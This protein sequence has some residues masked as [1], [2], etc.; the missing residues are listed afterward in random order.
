[1]NY[2]KLKNNYLPEFLALLSGRQKPSMVTVN[3]TGRCNQRCIYCEIGQGI[4]SEVTDILTSED[5]FWILDEMA[6]HGLHRISLCGGE[7]FLFE[8]L[9]DVIDY[10]SKKHIRCSIT[11]NGMTVFK[12]KDADFEILRRNNADI[13]LSI[14]SLNEE[15]QGLTRGV[16]T[17]L[18]NALLSFQKLKENSI[19]VTVLAAISKY[20]YR[21]L[22]D[23]ILN[24]HKIGIK[25]VLFQPVIHHSNYPDRQTLNDK[26]S[27]NIPTGQLEILMQ[28]L[29]QIRQFERKHDISTNVYR[30][31]P[32]IGAYIKAAERQDGKLFFEDVLK[33]FYC[34]E[35]YA[36][37][38]ITYDGGIQPCGLTRATVNI[39]E[40]KGLGLLELWED[41]TAEIKRDITNGHYYDYC[42]ACCHK[43]SR[44]MLASVM[45]YPMKNSSA[46]MKMIP[47]LVSRIG[48][49]TRKK[50]F[51]SN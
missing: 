46:L 35:V 9:M 45:K 42:N 16:P 17:A 4:N 7:P 34:R 1:M 24:A 44:N 2:S 29:R 5:L 20:N 21:D 11:T 41:A 25:Q 10:A 12:L 36:A 39:H 51:N 31:L 38:D 28:N 8:G 13:N 32:W 19:P 33:K 22:A 3:L 43:F 23:F 18:A 37:I 26:S 27:L 47:L 40:R 30:I 48:S 6:S 14:D 50:I 49:K 15:I